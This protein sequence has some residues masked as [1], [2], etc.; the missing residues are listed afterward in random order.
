MADIWVELNTA[1]LVESVKQD[2]EGLERDTHKAVQLLAAQA[3]AHIKEQV[4]VK[5][6]TRREMYEDALSQVEEVAPGIWAITLNAKAVWIEEGMPPHSM[7]D[8]LLRKGAKTAKD[9][10]LYKVIPFSHKK[11]PTQAGPS[12]QMM[13][14]AV[15]DELKKRSIPY[16]KIEREP[17]GAPKTGLLHKFDM[18]HGGGNIPTPNRPPG[19][20]GKPGWGKGAVGQ[21]MQGPNQAGGSGGGT[22]L[23]QGV[24]I[25]QNAITDKDGKPAMNK[26]GQ[27]KAT[28]SIMTFRVVSSKHRGLKWN[29]PGIEGTHFFEECETWVQNVWE[30]DILPELVRKYS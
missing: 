1:G 7:V 11:G 25:Y 18:N 3:H 27:Q 2:I 9:G 16:A 15:K 21:P 30:N 20:E 19:T 8:D 29:Y 4:Q 24:R 22:P 17:S 6:H 28:R 23:L 14:A 12:Q 10:S 5:L 13:T 26:Q